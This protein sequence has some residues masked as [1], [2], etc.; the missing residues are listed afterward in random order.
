LRQEELRQALSFSN[1]QVI[2]PPALRWKPIWPRRTIGLAVGLLFSGAFGLLALVVA[3]R[4][5]RTVRRAAQIE[6]AT[7]APILAVT[8]AENGRAPA[9]SEREVLAMVRRGTHNGDAARVSIAPIGRDERAEAVARAMADG[10]GRVATIT[11]GDPQLLP[12]VVAIPPVEDFA[13][14]AMADSGPV[15][16]VIHYGRTRRDAL[17]RSVR[18][19]R[20]AGATVVGIIVLCDRERQRRSIWT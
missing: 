8:L 6:E 7:G 10:N 5:D 12:R 15:A 9:L 1:V 20:A 3:D 17:D 18:L 19:L 14:A 4:A 16:L 11:N 13:A 2:D